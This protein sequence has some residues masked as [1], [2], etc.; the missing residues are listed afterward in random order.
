MRIFHFTSSGNAPLLQ[1]RKVDYG[2]GSENSV[3]SL[4]ILRRRSCLLQKLSLQPDT[5]HRTQG[6]DRSDSSRK[7]TCPI[8][9]PACQTL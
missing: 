3:E 4:S 7:E 1:N 5:E 9:Q 6:C 2:N 8:R